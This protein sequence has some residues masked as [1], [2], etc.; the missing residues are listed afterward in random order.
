ML[1]SPQGPPSLAEWINEFKT[2]TDSDLNQITQKAF[3]QVESPAVPLPVA[4][5][6]MQVG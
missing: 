4:P 2:R 1:H 6:A 5:T 3:D